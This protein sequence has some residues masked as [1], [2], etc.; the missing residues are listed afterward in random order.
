MG[1]YI[2]QIVLRHKVNSGRGSRK[3]KIL[4]EAESREQAEYFGKQYLEG[5]LN[6]EVEII[7]IAEE[8]Y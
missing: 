5:F 3:F 4:F 1:N 2:V 7:T 8:I 6:R